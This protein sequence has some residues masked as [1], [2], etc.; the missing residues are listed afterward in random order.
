MIVEGDFDANNVPSI[1]TPEMLGEFAIVPS[2][3]GATFVVGFRLK[4]TPVAMIAA[5]KSGNVM[6]KDVVP[7][8]DPLT[9]D[10]SV[11]RS[12]A[13]GDG[14][15]VVPYGASAGKGARMACFDARTGVRLWDVALQDAPSAGVAIEAG[16]VYYAT[17]RATYALSLAKGAPLFALGQ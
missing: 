6:W 17:G 5:V 8:V 10:L 9:T 15:V 3:Q 16:R 2:E 4:G 1:P 12:A 14:K 7:G 11:K 13:A